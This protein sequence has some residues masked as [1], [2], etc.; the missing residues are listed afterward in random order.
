MFDMADVTLVA[1][2]SEATLFQLYTAVRSQDFEMTGCA[3]ELRD[4]ILAFQFAAARRSYRER[5][6][7][8]DWRLILLEGAAVGWLVVDRRE[9]EICC[10]DIALVADARRQGIGS[11]LLRALQQE[12][13]I[14]GKPVTL[15]VQRANHGARAVYDRLGF[16]SIAET[17]C[18]VWMEWRCRDSRSRPRARAV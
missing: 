3:S 4:R 1:A 2:H 12:A 10:V 11:H 8:A 18:H 5:F 13:A 6:P 15:T 17:D 7:E 16:R 14:E 9:S